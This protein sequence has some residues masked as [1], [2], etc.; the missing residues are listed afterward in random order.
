MGTGLF[1]N[2]D[3][4]KK[5]PEC[6]GCICD[7]IK[8]LEKGTVIKIAFQEDF[9]EEDNEINFTFVCFDKETCCVTLIDPDDDNAVIVDCRTLIALE[10]VRD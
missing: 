8:T 1:G 4:K 3:C 10:I 7:V 5:K 6:E 9:L 2:E